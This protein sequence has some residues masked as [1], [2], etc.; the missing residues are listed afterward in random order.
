M[1]EHNDQME[2]IDFPEFP[3]TKISMK[4]SARYITIFNLSDIRQ[5]IQIFR[6]FDCPVVQDRLRLHNLTNT[7]GQG[8]FQGNFRAALMPKTRPRV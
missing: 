1:I 8:L 5:R 2:K 3:E 4:W 6:V 7:V